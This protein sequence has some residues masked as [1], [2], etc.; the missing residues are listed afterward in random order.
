MNPWVSGQRV[1]MWIQ[2]NN[3]LPIRFVCN[4]KHCVILMFSLGPCHKIRNTFELTGR[5]KHRLQ[6]ACFSPTV[7][8]GQ[9]CT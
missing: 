2:P 5:V 6:H 7:D 3:A 8:Y 4:K 9:Y 1:D